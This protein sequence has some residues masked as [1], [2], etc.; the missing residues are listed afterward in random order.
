MING[1][2]YYYAINI[3]SHLKNSNNGGFYATNVVL[4]EMIR[5]YYHRSKSGGDYSNNLDSILIYLIYHMVDK[6]GNPGTV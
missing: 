1:G 3:C 4:N 5:N 2:N 6:K